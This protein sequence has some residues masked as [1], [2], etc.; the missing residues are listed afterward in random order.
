MVE[1]VGVS[2]RGAAAIRALNEAADQYDTARTS[3]HFAEK[4]KAAKRAEIEER[5][6]KSLL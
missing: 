1:R 3:S 5:R 4:I 6:E 2:E